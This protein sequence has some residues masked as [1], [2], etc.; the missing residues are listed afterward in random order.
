MRNEKM[1]EQEYVIRGDTRWICSECRTSNSKKKRDCRSCRNPRKG[2]MDPRRQEIERIVHIL[3]TIHKKNEEG[4][5]VHEIREDTKLTEDQIR[6]R[7]RD[8]RL[9]NCVVIRAEAR[10]RHH[11]QLTSKGES[12]LEASRK[13]LE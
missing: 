10:T 3:R 12:V 6:P 11:Y 7:I 9:M 5:T 8:L 2:P 1:E 4:C 13:L